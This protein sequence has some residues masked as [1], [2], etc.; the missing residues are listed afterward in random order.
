MSLKTLNWPYN[1][2]LLLTDETEF[3]NI[4]NNPLYNK[5]NIK[6]YANTADITTFNNKDKDEIRKDI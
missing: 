4:I 6:N 3:K 1:E 2:S 5:N